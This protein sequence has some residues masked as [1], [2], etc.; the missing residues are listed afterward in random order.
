LGV[1]CA[2]RAIDISITLHVRNAKAIKRD[3]L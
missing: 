3:R 1:L 2:M